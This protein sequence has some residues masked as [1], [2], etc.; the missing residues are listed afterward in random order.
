MTVA[1]Q[2]WSSYQTSTPSTDGLNFVFIKATEGLGYVNPRATAQVAHAR[3]AGLTVGWYHYPH[4]ANSASAEADHFLTHTALRP[5]DLIALDWE[6]Y[7]Q[8]VTAAQARAYKSAF[9]S[10]IRLR[11]PRH[12]V[13]VYAD[14]TNW[15]T[16]DQDGNC[17]DGLW[18]AD[19]TTAGHPRIKDQWIIH[20]YANTP[21]D[22]NVAN[23]STVEAMREWANPGVK[24]P[25]T[26]P[27]AD[28]RI[29]LKHVIAAAK[30]DPQAPQGHGLHPADVKPVENALKAEKLLDAK[31]A[32]DGSFGSLTVTAYSRWQERCGYHGAD[33]NGIPGEASLKKLGVKHGFTVVA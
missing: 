18:I 21:V 2:D 19:Y 1:G 9:I 27:V 8:T 29:S 17:G 7:G 11:A 32:S 22:K 26:K 5:G 12:R 20:Q 14:R 28:L 15:T 30:A 33:A 24:K 25:V 13:L 6:W 4:I 31:Y 10:R 3:A 23:F 16:V